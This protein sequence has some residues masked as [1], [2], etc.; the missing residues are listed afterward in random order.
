[1]RDARL[2]FQCC[3]KKLDKHGAGTE[4]LLTAVLQ[5]S[6]IR[7]GV[8]FLRMTPQISSNPILLCVIDLHASDRGPFYLKCRECS[9]SVISPNFCKIRKHTD[10]QFS[11]DVMF[12]VW[13]PAVLSHLI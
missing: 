7:A 6:F 2:A 3:S 10:P 12:G 13:R 1:M 11:T 4:L 8:T 5:V 9:M